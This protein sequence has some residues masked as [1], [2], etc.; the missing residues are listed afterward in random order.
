MSEALPITYLARHG[1][2][3]S[4]VLG[5]GA[6][7]LAT[8]RVLQ[9]RGF[10]V[11]IYARQLPPDTTSNVA[12]AMWFCGLASVTSNARMLFAFARDG[13]LPAWA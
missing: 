2:H 11:T 1:G 8:A 3:L 7:G 6:V 12:G 13:G 5:C 10:A 4:A 9:D